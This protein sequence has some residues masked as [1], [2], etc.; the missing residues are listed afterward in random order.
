MAYA[1]FQSVWIPLK[2]NSLLFLLLQFLFL[3]CSTASVVSKQ[4]K[5]Q[6]VVEKSEVEKDAQQPPPPPALEEL[7]IVKNIEDG[8]PYQISKVCGDMPVF[9]EI[10]ASWCDACK[11]LYPVTEKLRNMFKGKV[12]FIRI[13]IDEKPYEGDTEIK[14]FYPVSSPEVLGFSRSDALPRVVVLN[15]DD[16]EPYADLSG[17]Y[18]FLYYYGLLSEL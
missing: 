18:P 10:S 14:V 13:M 5:N 2:K 4:D 8:R 15:G 16:K 3:S 1:L 7:S 17:K 6:D 9:I 11:E 12:C